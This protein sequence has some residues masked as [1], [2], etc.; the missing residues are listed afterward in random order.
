MYI[1]TI[2]DPIVDYSAGYFYEDAFHIPDYP[3]YEK[4][5]MPFH[6]DGDTSNLVDKNGAPVILN[7][8]LIDS[9]NWSLVE[10]KE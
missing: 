4:I 10:W 8:S 5:G 3:H 7:I 2:I 9:P 6:F 1:N